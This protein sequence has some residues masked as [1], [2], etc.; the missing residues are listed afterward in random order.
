MWEHL[1][2]GESLDRRLVCRCVKCMVGKGFVGVGKP[3]R[4]GAKAWGMAKYPRS[5]DLFVDFHEL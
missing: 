5:R 3:Q 2:S 1:W 4:N